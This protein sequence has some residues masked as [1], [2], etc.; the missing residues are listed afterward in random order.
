MKVSF[1]FSGTGLDG[2]SF[3]L[4]V[5]V[6]GCDMTKQL[7]V[8]PRGAISVLLTQSVCSPHLDPRLN[9]APSSVP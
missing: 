5:K 4:E 3:D 2:V 9:R 8:S 6:A 7:S 1:A